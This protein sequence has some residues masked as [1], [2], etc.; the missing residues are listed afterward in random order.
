MS[1]ACREV[2]LTDVICSAKILTG[3]ARSLEDVLQ[4]ASL[5]DLLDPN[6][7]LCAFK[8]LE[9][10]HWPVLAR[11]AVHSDKVHSRQFAYVSERKQEM[12]WN[13][14]KLGTK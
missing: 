8:S 12:I 13:D 11:F 14:S 7:A 6:G 3:F 9:G 5:A 1:S 4:H 2:S 10:G